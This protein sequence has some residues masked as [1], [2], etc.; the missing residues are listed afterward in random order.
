[1]KEGRRVRMEGRDIREGAVVPGDAPVVGD[2]HR[3][4]GVARGCLKG[5]V[6]GA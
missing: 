6:A 5:G 3:S 4:C 1:M 2:R